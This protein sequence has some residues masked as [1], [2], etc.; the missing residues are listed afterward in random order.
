L[1]V[2]LVLII[3]G[4]TGVLLAFYVEIER[5]AYPHL[6]TAHP[7]ALPVSYEAVYQRLARLPVAL[8]GQ[9]WRME[10]PPAG[11]IIT[12][13]YQ[14]PGQP[15]RMVTLDPV[16]FAVL[17]DAPWGGTFFT[18][19]Y[20]VHMNLLFGPPGKIAMGIFGLAMAVLLVCGAGSWL[21][22]PGRWRSKF[23]FK[24]QAP[25]TQRNY[26]LHKLSGGG[27]LLL[28]LLVT[29][30]GAMIC[31]PN[32]VR[33]L[34][35]LFGPMK[36]TEPPPNPPAAPGAARIT[37]DEA[38][39]QGAA[40]IPGS[41]VVWIHVPGTAS[42]VY[43]LRLRLPGGPMTRF[44]KTHVY[45]NQFT[46]QVIGVNNPRADGFGDWVLDWIVPLHDG[47]AL[48]LAGR[49]IVMLLGLVP[50]LLYATGFLRWK[51]KREGRLLGAR[52]RAGRAPSF[53][54]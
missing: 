15:V 30:T 39:R 36:P 38:L 17:R 12:S 4:L 6:R 31:L 26:D 42:D 34:L 28:L 29:L 40:A 49:V 23:T 43:D 16:T 20:D 54:D 5:T 52:R 53:A 8:P 13:R 9:H 32:Q 45:L 22:P 46:G 18:W 44:P 37:V 27:S 7:Q 11:G 25:P 24:R 51:Q 3:G 50:A 21:L 14:V 35:S 19:I 48:G 2:G 41:T 1:T 47:K 33:P 10:I